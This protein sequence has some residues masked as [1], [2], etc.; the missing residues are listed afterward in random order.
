MYKHETFEGIML[1]LDVLCEA[2]SYKAFFPLVMS[3]LE[4]Q[5]EAARARS[6]TLIVNKELCQRPS[7][8]C[9]TFLVPPPRSHLKEKERKITHY[10]LKCTIQS[11]KTSFQ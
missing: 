11:P 4:R 5:R 2:G 8:K 9:A 1:H 3:A 6:L 7:N 10:P